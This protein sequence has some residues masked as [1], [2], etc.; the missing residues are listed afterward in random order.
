MLEKKVSFAEA[1]KQGILITVLTASFLSS[2]NK[3]PFLE[4]FSQ[5]LLTFTLA[6]LVAVYTQKLAGLKLGYLVKYKHWPVGLATGFFLSA[7]TFFAAP[8]F[9]PGF[10]ELTAVKQWRLGKF[11]PNLRQ[12]DYSLVGFAGPLAN[13]L[14]ATLLSVFQNNH[15]INLAIK[16]NLLVMLYFMAPLPVIAGLKR[17]PEGVFRFSFKGA[18]PGLAMFIHSRVLYFFSATLMV[19]YSTLYFVTGHSFL[20]MALLSSA[21]LT[22]WYAA[23]VEKA[24]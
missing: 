24:F 17:S 19:L 23:E 8:L 18:T 20:I 14:T 1:E 13:L 11:T 2:F 6:L 10:L 9:S 21:I 15:F 12:K 22:Y 16:S 4:R 3:T 5:T 7:L